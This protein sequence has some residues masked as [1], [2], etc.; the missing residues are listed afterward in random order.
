MHRLVLQAQL[1]LLRSKGRTAGGPPGAVPAAHPN[2]ARAAAAACSAAPSGAAARK[3]AM[4]AVTLQPVAVIWVS[5]AVPLL[6]PTTRL[7]SVT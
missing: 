4:R 1:E 7:P 2:T 5:R 3:A 6:T